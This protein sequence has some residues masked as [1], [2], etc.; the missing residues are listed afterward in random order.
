MRGDSTCDLAIQLDP[1]YADAHGDRGSACV[2][3]T[4]GDAVAA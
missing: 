1:N 4:L 2:S 3:Q